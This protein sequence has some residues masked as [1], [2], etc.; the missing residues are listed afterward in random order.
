M[1]VDVDTLIRP[2]ATSL[3]VWTLDH[4]LIQHCFDYAWY[5]ADVCLAVYP[6]ATGG[7]RLAAARL[8][9]PCMV[10]AFSA[11]VVFASQPNR[12][13]ERGVADEANEIAV[14]FGHVFERLEFGR[15]F[16]DAALA[17]LG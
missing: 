14:G 12:S 17:A 9:G 3:D 13:I 6:A 1:V 16:G 2:I 8:R 11:E 5:R 10:E 4:Q 7:T 15:D